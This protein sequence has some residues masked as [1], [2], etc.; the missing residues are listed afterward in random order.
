MPNFSPSQWNQARDYLFTHGRP[1]EQARYNYHFE[2]G[3]ADAVLAALKVFQNDDGGFGHGLE[4]DLRTLASSVIA[5]STAFHI[6]REIEADAKHGQVQS[7]IDFLMSAYDPDA[8]VWPIVP[9]E[10]ED[11]PHAPWWFYE[12]SA[13]NFGDFLHNPRAE[14]LG[15]LYH[16]GCPINHGFMDVVLDGLRGLPEQMA[17]YDLRSYLGLASAQGLSVRVQQDLDTILSVRIPA[18]IA[19]DPTDWAEHG[20]LLPLAAAPLPESYAAKYVADELIEA[21]LDYVIASQN[22]DGSW[23]VPWEW[24]AFGKEAWKQAEQDWKG[25]FILD[26]LRSL[27][28]YGRT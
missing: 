16:F 9:P 10:V 26:N 19:N 25:V 27:R 15:H 14:V 6:L 8:R 17:L 12:T 7:A 18:T 24:S 3:A 11:G 2:D 4:P 5:T 28:A 21:N 23:P 20:G 1:L 13:K 22:P